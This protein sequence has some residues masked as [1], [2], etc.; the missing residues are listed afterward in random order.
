[1]TFRFTMC[2]ACG[3]HY[4]SEETVGLGPKIKC[5]ACNERQTVKEQFTPEGPYTGSEFGDLVER[6]TVRFSKGDKQLILNR[7]IATVACGFAEE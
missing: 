2:T 1:M 5:V 6:R 4:S 3:R 7:L